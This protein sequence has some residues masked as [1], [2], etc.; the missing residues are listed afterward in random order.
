MV[1]F[2]F[3]NRPESRKRTTSLSNTNQFEDREEE[4]YSGKKLARFNIDIII[5][6]NE[7]D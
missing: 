3:F 6:M 7:T 2:N 5:D 1:K 4:E